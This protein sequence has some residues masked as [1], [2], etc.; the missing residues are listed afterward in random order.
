MVRCTLVFFFL[1]LQVDM[2]D[3]LMKISAILLVIWYCLSIIG[4]DVHTCSETGDSFVHMS[5][6][7]HSCHD[8]HD[9]H[10]DWACEHEHDEH[11]E[12][13][14]EHHHDGRCCEDEYQVISLTGLRSD[15]DSN[16]SF[17]GGECPC[18]METECDTFALLADIFDYRYFEE[19]DSGLIVADAQ[20]LL[21]IWRI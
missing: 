10:C 2:K 19:P 18:I 5:F 17:H 13:P 12:E 14:V 3:A 16:G 4:F 20:P 8:I 15:D 1:H 21:S 11:C 9:D 6:T 7:S